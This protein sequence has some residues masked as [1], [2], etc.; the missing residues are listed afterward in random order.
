MSHNYKFPFFLCWMSFQGKQMLVQPLDSTVHDTRLWP[1]NRCPSRYSTFPCHVPTPLAPIVEQGLRQ[2]PTHFLD[3]KYHNKRDG[4]IENPHTSETRS[5]ASETTAP[6]ARP[7]RMIR[8]SPSA[9]DDTQNS[10]KAATP[11][12]LEQTTQEFSIQK[13]VKNSTETS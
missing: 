13:P 4:S 7:C 10:S 6:S 1:Q 11:E 3:S 9:G 2:S 12:H 5:A 8:C